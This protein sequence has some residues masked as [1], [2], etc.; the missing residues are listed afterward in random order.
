MGNCRAYSYK[1]NKM[2]ENWREF[3]LIKGKKV[4]VWK[5]RQNNESLETNHGLENGATQTFTDTP[6]CKGKLNTKAYVTA[7]D[8]CAWNILREIRK[9]EEN[10]YVEF[11]DGKL[12]SE[13]VTSINFDKH[14]PKNFTPC[15]PQT[16]ISES[17][18]DKIH[19]AGNARYTRKRDGLQN[20]AVHHPWGWEIYSRR[21]DLM[22]DKFPNHIADLTSSPYDVGTILVGEIVC[23]REDGTDDFKSTTRICRS[24]PPVARKLIEDKEVPEP[25]YIVFDMLFYNGKDLSN[26]SYR[27]RA[28]LWRLFSTNLIKPVEYYDVTP[29]TWENVAKDNRWEGF[30]VMD[31]SSVPGDKLFSWDGDAKRPKG[32]HKLKTTKTE[33]VV[34]F[35]AVSGT[36]K[37][38]NKIGAVFVKQKNPDTQEFFNCGKVGSG[39]TEEDIDYLTNLCKEKNIP[40]LNK[41]TE[42]KNVDLN[43]NNCLVIEIEYGER[44]SDTNKFR[45]PVYLRLRNDK[46]AEE[47]VAE[48]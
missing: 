14:L 47:C 4:W 13:T 11:I 19:S 6:G 38:L 2:T 16:N 24:D 20:S 37:R 26:V 5:I 33:D 8:N 27:E 21:M 7:F 23:Q 48:I 1:G 43:S 3:R 35:A 25:L 39:F 42:I 10:G 46:S 29:K 12:V 40:I 41:D 34:V 45:F 30:V 36:G 15:K 17:A 31:C 28:D 44:Q 22:T 9:K 32:H 18:L